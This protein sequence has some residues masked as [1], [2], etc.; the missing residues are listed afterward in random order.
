M[1]KLFYRKHW[2]LLHIAHQF[3]PQGS[4]GFLFTTCPQ[5]AHQ[6]LAIPATIIGALAIFEIKLRHDSVEEAGAICR[7]FAV[8]L[9]VMMLT[10]YLQPLMRSHLLLVLCKCVY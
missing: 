4:C 1:G 6:G 3:V 10:V 9:Q 8:Y 2:I 7:C 5:H